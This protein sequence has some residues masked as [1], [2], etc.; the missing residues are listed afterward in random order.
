MSYSKRYKMH[1]FVV[2]IMQKRADQRML[3][4]CQ[5]GAEKGD[6][7]NSCSASAIASHIWKILKILDDAQIVSPDRG[8][9]R[10]FETGSIW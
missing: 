2:I 7:L 5:T 6:C 1:N 8:H 4:I 9:P 10:Y 3:N